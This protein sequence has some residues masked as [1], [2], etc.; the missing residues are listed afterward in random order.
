MGGPLAGRVAVVTG[1]AGGIGAATA[2]RLA[3][4]GA[5]V[6]L[7]DAD[8]EGRLE[9]TAERAGGIAFRGDPADPTFAPG[10][11]AGVEAELGTVEILV[12][13]PAEPATGPFPD[14]DPA[15]WWRRIE[16][17]LTAAFRLC[18]EVAPG[19]RR[20][21]WGRIVLV[22]PEGGIAGP[23]GETAGGASRAGLV[24][25]GR[26]LGRELGP[27]GIN[28]NV[29]VPGAEAPLGRP[30]RPRDVAAIAAF[31]CSP[32]GGGLIGQVIQPN[33]GELRCQ[34]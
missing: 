17:G 3:G 25:L 4:E 21:G 10:L 15:R 20:A 16:V 19:M 9:S 2:E 27:D 29:I 11:V 28:T 8:P 26:S 34:R 5:R 12:S 1:A 18:R 31:L 7:A 32:A 6:A 24:S 13:T 30:G 33:G 22:G 23:A 14:E